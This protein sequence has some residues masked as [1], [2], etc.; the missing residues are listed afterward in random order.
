MRGSGSRL[1]LRLRLRLR[2]SLYRCIAVSLFSSGRTAEEVMSNTT[3]HYSR[4]VLNALSLLQ[5]IQYIVG[6]LRHFV[7]DLFNTCM[8]L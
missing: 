4:A 8:T 1:R 7:L 5:E 3:S 2:V 6:L